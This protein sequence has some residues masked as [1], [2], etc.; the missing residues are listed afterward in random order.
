MPRL[1]SFLAFLAAFSAASSAAAYETAASG[2]ASDVPLVIIRFNQ[3]T[4][5]Y[6]RQ[7]YNAVA[8]AVEIKPEVVFDVVSFVPETGNERT[9]DRL[10]NDALAKTSDVVNS[11]RGMG[12]PQ[13]HMRVSRESAPGLRSHEIHVYVQ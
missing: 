9:D 12:I 1:F 13:E 2:G 6:D 3:R 10:A 8:K 11:L 4:V 7:L 5:M